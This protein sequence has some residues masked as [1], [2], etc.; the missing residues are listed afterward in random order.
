MN[1]NSCCT[2][3]V[4][5]ADGVH[6]EPAAALQDLVETAIAVAKEE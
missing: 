3:G 4:L 5:V 2:R 1:S 6:A